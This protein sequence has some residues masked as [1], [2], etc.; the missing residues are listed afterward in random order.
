MPS[1]TILNFIVARD[2]DQRSMV[3]D[4]AEVGFRLLHNQGAETLILDVIRSAGEHQIL[5]NQ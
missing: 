3:T 4:A 5:E 1:D 2:N